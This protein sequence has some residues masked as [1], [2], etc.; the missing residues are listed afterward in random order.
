MPGITVSRSLQLG[1]MLLITG[2][3][4]AQ[5]QRQGPKIYPAAMSVDYNPLL[6][7]GDDAQ[8]AL[9]MLRRRHVRA[10]VSQTVAGKSQNPTVQNVALTIAREQGKVYRQLRSMARTFNF[11]L[12]PRRD[13]ED[14]PAG[15]R[16]AELAGPE[17]DSGYIALLLKSTTANVSR[18]EAEVALPRMPSNWSLW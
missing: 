2:V 12:P 16:V 3:L 10:G 17:M 6:W 8:F 4:M 13:L 11:P 5:D 7:Q 1:C 9:D 14:C 18:F 15:S